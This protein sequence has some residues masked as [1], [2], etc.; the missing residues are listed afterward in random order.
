M[1]KRKNIE[2]E[3]KELHQQLKSQ[4]QKAKLERDLDYVKKGLKQVRREK[5]VRRLEGARKGAK[6]VGK[7]LSKTFSGTEPLGIDLRPIR[8]RKR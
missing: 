2:V 3:I 7:V 8:K 5:L 4:K 6:M 1:F